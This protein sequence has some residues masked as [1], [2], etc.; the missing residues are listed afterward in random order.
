MRSCLVF[1]WGPDN[2][3]GVIALCE[4]MIAAAERA[5]DLEQALN[6][7]ATRVTPLATLGRTAAAR[8]E[9]RRGHAAR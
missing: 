3:D 9:A 2:L 8:D 4:E 1:L 7:H 5:G 6:G